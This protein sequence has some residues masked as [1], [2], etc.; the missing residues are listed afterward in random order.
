MQAERSGSSSGSCSGLPSCGQPSAGL[1]TREADR[2]SCVR[3]ASARYSVSVRLI[4]ADV[5]LRTDD[6]RLLIG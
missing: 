2:L 6:G 4:G 3:F 1:I 5:R